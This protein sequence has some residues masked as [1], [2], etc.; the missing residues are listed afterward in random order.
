M[1]M[2]LQYGWT[3]VRPQTKTGQYTVYLIYVIN[4]EYT[5]TNSI[6]LNYLQRFMSADS[7]HHQEEILFKQ[8]RKE[9]DFEHFKN[10]V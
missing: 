8:K 7:F 3:T 5:A 4:S 6:K 2:K 1:Q 10:C 9:N